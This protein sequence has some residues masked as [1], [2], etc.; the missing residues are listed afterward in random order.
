MRLDEDETAG[1]S[2]RSAQSIRSRCSMLY[3]ND[4]QI[5][6]GVCDWALQIADW[7]GKLTWAACP[8]NNC[9]RCLWEEIQI[10]I[11]VIWVILAK[12]ESK[13]RD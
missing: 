8:K 7:R 11:D 9:P 12:C 2:Q 10:R 1:E 4:D 6:H 3:A 5:I 13:I